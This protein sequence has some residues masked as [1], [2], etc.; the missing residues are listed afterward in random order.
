MLDLAGA[1][2]AG[3]QE[4]TDL[5]TQFFIFGRSRTE[6]A[7]GHRLE[8]VEFSFH[9]SAKERPVHAH[10]VRQEQVTSTAL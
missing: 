7:V 2:K 6:A 5:I 8:N 10:R 9:P 3:G 1:G 4:L